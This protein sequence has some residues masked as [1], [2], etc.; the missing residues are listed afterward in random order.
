MIENYASSNTY[1]VYSMLDV[2]KLLYFYLRKY[3]ARHAR[4]WQDNADHTFVD[5]NFVQLFAN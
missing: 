4:V 2:N 5:L 1:Y 3:L